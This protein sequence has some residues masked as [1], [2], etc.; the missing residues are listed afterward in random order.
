MKL[1]V[2]TSIAG[3]LHTALVRGQALGCDVIQLFTHAPGRWKARDLSREE[4]SL[5][6]D[7]ALRTGVVPLAIHAAYLI[8]LGTP[9]PTMGKRSLAALEK[10]LQHAEILRIPFVVVHPGAHM[11]EGEARGLVRVARRLDTLHRRTRGFRTRILLENTSGQGTSLGYRFEHLGTLVGRVRD[12]ERLGVC[13]DTCHLHAA[14]YDLREGYRETLEQLDRAVGVRLVKV[15]HLNDSKTRLAGRVDR[16]QHI[17][18][19]TIGRKGFL[20]LLGDPRFLDTPMVLETP[21][22]D[23]D[24]LHQD[25]KNLAAVRRLATAGSDC[26][27]ASCPFH[28]DISKND[29]EQ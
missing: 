14:G 9:C 10:E 23:G 20:H 29:H 3:G 4:V 15:L 2:H 12:P 21:K 27:A 1:G 25:R 28:F 18:K 8:N 7:T 26:K 17:G 16:H 19:G 13:L 24:G 5:F 11:G 22:G 6:R